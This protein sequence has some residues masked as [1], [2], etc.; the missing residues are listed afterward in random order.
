MNLKAARKLIE[1]TELEM[2]AKQDI[3]RGLNILAKYDDNISCAFEH[4]KMWAGD[5]E[6][7]VARMSREEVIEMARLGWFESED[8][9]AHY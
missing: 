7:T 3:V 8:S 5:F 1:K 2:H 6:S 4:D 9:W